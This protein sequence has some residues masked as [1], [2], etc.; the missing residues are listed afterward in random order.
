MKQVSVASRSLSLV[1]F[2]RS[3]DL[4]KLELNKSIFGISSSVNVGEDL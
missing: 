1:E 4:R 2:D 3:L